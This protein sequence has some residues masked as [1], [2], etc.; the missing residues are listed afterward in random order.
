[1]GTK[2]EIKKRFVIMQHLRETLRNKLYA[3]SMIGI[4]YVS[5]R[6]AD[7]ATFLLLMSM[8]AVPLLFAKENWIE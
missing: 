3:L 4:G 7:D 5:T 8:F 6:W 2:R 1:M